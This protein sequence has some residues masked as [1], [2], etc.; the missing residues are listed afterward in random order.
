MQIELCP[1]TGRRHLQAF[2]QFSTRRRFT[3]MIKKLKPRHVEV[4][5]HP[6][7]AYKY[8]FKEESRAPDGWQ[9]KSDLEPVFSGKRTDL[10]EACEIVKT[11]G[12]RA[13]A[14]QMP[15]SLVRHYSGF[16]KLK[17]LLDP[18]MR[19]MP[20]KAIWLVGPAGVGK[21]RSIPPGTGRIRVDRSGAAWYDDCID[22]SSVLLDDFDGSMQLMEFLQASDC[23][24]FPMRVMGGFYPRTYDTLYVTSNLD[25]SQCYPKAKDSQQ[26]AILRRFEI[27]TVGGGTV[28][29]ATSDT[30]LA[31]GNVVEAPNGGIILQKPDL[32]NGTSDTLLVP[33]HT[34]SDSKELLRERIKAATHAAPPKP[35]KPKPR[36]PS[37]PPPLRPS[38]P[39]PPGSTLHAFFRKPT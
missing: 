37:S 14:E 10:L 30:V 36:R 35:W 1:E 34:T 39:P 7:E 31:P 18:G 27:R 2:V 19:Y 29:P 38:N 17:N 13:L 32:E 8:C 23:Y 6:K 15:D 25:P 21:T 12:L 3:T 33:G 24:S 20:I 26:E 28:L 16:A 22:R 9:L 11:S 4:A 5:K